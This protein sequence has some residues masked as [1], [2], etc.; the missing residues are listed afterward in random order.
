MT[1]YYLRA[2]GN[3]ANTGLGITAGTAWQTLA[4]AGTQL[5]PGDRLEI[6]S[7]GGTFFISGE[8][9]VTLV[10]TSGSW[11]TVTNYS[12]ET[13]IFD[14]TGGTFG[15][16]DAILSFGHDSEYA[17]IGGFVVRNNAQGSA[18]GRGVEIE[19]S[20]SPKA[21]D[22]IF[23]DITI[24]DVDER[25]FGGGGNDITLIGIE[26]YNY[27]LS[28]TGQALGGGGWASGIA[29]F[30][31]SDNSLPFGW[32]M[33]E[34]YV[35]D[36]WGEGIITLRIG[37]Q[38]ATPG[39]GDG[40]TVEDC[41]VENGF[42]VSCYIDKGHGILVR[43][44]SLLF[45]DPTYQRSGRNTDG[46]KFAVEGTPLHSS[47]GVNNVWIYNNIV[48]GMR[49][50]FSWFTDSSVAASTYKNVKFWH[51]S[52]YSNERACR[53]E[54]V[55]GAANTPSGC[56][57]KNNIVDGT[58]TT[59]NNAS[60]W[61]FVSND[62]WNNGVPGV[63]T[64]TSSFS[65]D[66]LFTSPSTSYGGASGFELTSSS[67]C[68][69]AGVAI[70]DVTTDFNGN[71]RNPITPTIG[72]FEFVSASAA[73][74]S[75]MT[76][77]GIVGSTIAVTGVGFTPVAIVFWWNGRTEAVDT[78]GAATH[79]RGIGFAVSASARRAGTNISTNG[80][81]PMD[82][83]S[84]NTPSACVSVL[85]ASGTVDGELEL[86]SMDADGFTLV[87]D[88]QFSTSYRI[89]YQAIGGED[90][91]NAATGQATIPTSAGEMAVTGVGF[92]ADWVLMFSTRQSTAPPVT[93]G[94]SILAIGAFNA[95]GQQAVWCGGSND[96][97]TPSQ[98][99]AY[100]REDECF[101]LP[102]STVA[103]IDT[104]A[105]FGSVT[106]DGFT[107][108]FLEVSG[109]A[110]YLH[111]LAIQGGSCAIGGILTQTDTVTGIT[112]LTPDY[113]ATGGLLFSANRAESAADTPTDNDAWSMGAFSSTSLRGAAAVMDEDAKAAAEV[114][115]AIE[116]DGVYANISTAAAI[117]GVMD[118]SAVANGSVTFIMD[119]ADPSQC[120]V[121]YLIFGPEVITPE[122]TPTSGD[123]VP[124]SGVT[125]APETTYFIRIN[126]AFGNP[127]PD[128]GALY[129]LQVA[130]TVGSV[131]SATITI[132]GEYPIDYLKKDGVIEI[133]RHPQNRQPYLLFNKIF[134][135]RQ[136][137]FSVSGGKRTWTLTAY[138]PNYLISDPAGQRGRIVA[139]AA[140]TSFSTQAGDYADD[141]IKAIARENVGTLATDTDRDLSA[142]LSI[143]ADLSAGPLL[144]KSFSNRV[145][146]PVFNEICQAS[147]TAGT[148]LAWDIVCTQP[149]L[150]G[151]YAL[152]L[153]TYTGQRGIDHR[154]SSN[155]PVLIGLDYGNLDDV[156]INEDWTAEESWIRVGGKGEGE[157]RAYATGGDDD[158]IGE[159]P[160][161]RR[162]AFVNMSNVSDP[163]ALA[164]EVDT[165]LRAGVP[166]P[167][168]RGRIISTD[169]ARFDAEWG[170]GDFLT[171]QAIIRSFDARA[172]SMVVKFN[173]D[174]GEDISA[175]L[176]GEDVLP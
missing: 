167:D 51:N 176:R 103:S 157:F 79:K 170:Y 9:D 98:T 158:R 126:D 108:D 154:F 143:Q 39:S 173:R 57:Y 171:A 140:Q 65:L 117:Q 137:V 99:L 12:G 72:A 155:Q 125:G 27:C 107:L 124:V 94:D 31:Y 8:H 162:E 28:N 175:H 102:S 69:N 47:Y 110:V 116:F 131:G 87:V 53:I 113:T 111:Y 142:Y 88:N 156:E 118:V 130:Q 62:W 35:H 56:E 14:G 147:I 13:P 106:A 77:T 148:Y 95:D 133:W 36:G 109:T 127:M 83:D 75:F 73:T 136:R 82:N 54:S 138:D 122:P 152:E 17:D 132:P 89:F 100:C 3:N 49:D 93:G 1:T 16:T 59:L 166:R 139:Y 85:S 81:N 159:S 20:I 5:N 46:F 70:S 90:I 26:V 18:T 50:T 74:N 121:W 105:V 151:D 40:M 164:D 84:R 48:A 129:S 80:A 44:T 141:M 41:V 58:M 115:T 67:P 128:V 104:R 15:S 43:R 160:F 60:A 34:C 120:F 61:S 4:Y 55:P 86:D 150:N 24:H 52:G 29:P 19:S 38:D 149:P 146:L 119:D 76:G 6:R 66:P 64:H 134:Y 33:Q 71:A 144:S 96:A 174:G 78:V 114:S 42:S 11:I 7:A 97:V 112:V 32:L 37:V 153:R 21:H 123:I 30:S 10:G 172:D 145:L 45:N 92:A 135:L 169:Q 91:V 161:N 163:A 23:R 63:G 25:G 2:D 22:L 101:A 68:I 165:A 168:Y